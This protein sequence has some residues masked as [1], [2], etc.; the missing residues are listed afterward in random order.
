MTLEPVGPGSPALGDCTPLLVDAADEYDDV[1]QVSCTFDS[2]PVNTYSVQV[3]VDGGYYIGGAEDVLTVIDPSL[4]YTTGGG[5]FYW[6]GTEDPG[7]GYPGDR[8]NF[9]YTI[10]YNRNL[11][12]IQGSLLLIRHLP[13]DTKYRIK[14]NALDGLAIGDQGDFGWASF[15]GK[16]TYLEPGWLEPIGNHAFTLYVE[17][18][19]EPGSGIDKVWL[20]TRDNDGQV[21]PDM[22]MTRP[23]SAH[24][25]EISGG[26]IVV[27][28]SGGTGNN[29]PTADFSYSADGLTVDLTDQS[30]DPGGSI[31]AW[32]WDFGDGNSSDVQNPSHTYAAD[33]VYE[34]SLTVTDNEGATDTT[35]QQ[36]TVSG[37]SPSGEM[38]VG[39]LTG[40][41]RSGPRNKWTAEVEIL[42]LDD[43]GNPVSGAEVTGAW[44]DGANG[45][46][47]CVTDGS[48]LC[49]VTKTNIN[50]NQSSFT[51]TVD[52]VTHASLTYNESLNVV[53]SI[54]V[55]Q[56]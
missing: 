44:S 20:E 32:Q 13:D 27:P 7:A 31:A 2:L 9:G 56:P 12:N 40:T 50:G 23:G 1:V 15:S 43:L 48:G 18:H 54:V 39:G 37:S 30:R 26:N 6:P 28:H 45:A 24:A 52:L 5:W 21:I 25:V 36:V 19:D 4:G 17:D 53:T 49:T 10:K 11:K 55:S 3:V 41:A 34:V 33:G 51:L 47:T 14:S 22:S 35:V 38:Y 8:T 42:I 46:G 16:A 29:P